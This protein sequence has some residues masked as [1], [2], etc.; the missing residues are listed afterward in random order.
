MEAVV[1]DL[2][3]TLVAAPT[4]HE[5]ARAAARLAAVVGCDGPRVDRYLR[6]TWRARH[7]GSLSTLRQLAEHLIDEVGGPD[8]AVRPLAD[9]YRL[10][11][12]ERLVAD[13]SVLCAL[14]ALRA[15]GLRLGILSDA[16]AEVAAAWHVGSL[17]TLVDT[18]V[19]SCEAAAVKPDQRLYGR[20]CRELSA[21]AGRTL[22]VG[23]GGGEELH[24]AVA[25][26]MA[27]L[28][29][30]RRG[31]AGAMV[32]GAVEWPGP[33]LERVEDLPAYVSARL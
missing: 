25:A 5:R 6:E 1:L 29:V 28:A 8:E 20:I 14:T 26:G 2:F 7:D 12:Q 10:L 13:P 22:Y 19:F 15:G 27:A 31:P 17:A 24:G 4:P 32:F 18:A 3:G 16:S 23:D 30:R 9:Q 33:V 11:G 21:P